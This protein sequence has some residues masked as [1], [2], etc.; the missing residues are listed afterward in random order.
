MFHFLSIS[1]FKHIF[2]YF[3]LILTSVFIKTNSGPPAAGYLDA[4]SILILR[5]AEY[6]VCIHY[7]GVYTDKRRIARLYIYPAS[8][9]ISGR[10]Q[11]LDG[12]TAMALASGP[13]SGRCQL[14]F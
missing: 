12:I 4:C 10:W 11:H 13:S 2:F 8:I 1:F 5:K 6:R 7:G 9:D 14:N 3:T